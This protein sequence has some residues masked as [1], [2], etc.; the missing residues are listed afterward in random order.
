MSW[1]RMEGK[2]ADQE[3]RNP[4]GSY[5]GLGFAVAVIAVAGVLAPVA[6]LLLDAYLPI[7]LDNA[8]YLGLLVFLFV[9]FII[10]PFAVSKLVQGLTGLAPV[11][12]F[13]C[14]CGSFT[15]LAME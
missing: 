10:F 11:R 5:G 1:V 2:S 13:S 8:I 15:F 12:A 14:F 3:E 7:P 9:F 6:T 4:R